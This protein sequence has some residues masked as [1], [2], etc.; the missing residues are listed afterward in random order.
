MNPF[1]WK[2]HIIFIE[3]NPCISEPRHFIPVLLNIQL[4]LSLCA[5][6]SLSIS[7]WKWSI[8]TIQRHGR[9]KL[10]GTSK[11]PSRLWAWYDVQRKFILRSLSFSLSTAPLLSPCQRLRQA[12]KAWRNNTPDLVRSWVRDIWPMASSGFGDWEFFAVSTG[13][14][15]IWGKPLAPVTDS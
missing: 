2:A 8:W 11:N 10:L 6:A 7:S 12:F 5:S 15:Y 9:S 3:R 4:S 1:I 13:M 14:C